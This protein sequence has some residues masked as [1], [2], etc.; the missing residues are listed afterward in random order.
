[1]RAMFVLLSLL[2]GTAGLIVLLDYIQGHSIFESW[3]SIK[4][5]LSSAQGEDYFLII[6]FILGLFVMYWLHE[7]KKK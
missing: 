7:K 5:V 2:A 3:K 6:I 1:M 4:I